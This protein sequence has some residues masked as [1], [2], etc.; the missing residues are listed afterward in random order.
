MK[1]VVSFLNK[2]PTAIYSYYSMKH[3]FGY[4]GVQEFSS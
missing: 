3:G 4:D 1:D 2:N